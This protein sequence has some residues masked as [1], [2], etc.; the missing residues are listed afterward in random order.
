M[1]N[2][3]MAAVIIMALV[4]VVV[5]GGCSSPTQ[6]PAQTTPQQ[7]EAQP[8]QTVEQPQAQQQQEAAQ[9]LPPQL[10]EAGD[11][12]YSDNLDQSIEELSQLE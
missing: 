11:D 10:V 8:A 6:A 1:K 4:A 9:Q 3:L 12:I 5:I 2:A 7:P